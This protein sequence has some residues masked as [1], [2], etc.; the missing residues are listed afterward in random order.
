MSAG[1]QESTL[2]YGRWMAIETTTDSDNAIQTIQT[3]LILLETV[4]QNPT[5]TKKSNPLTILTQ[6][7]VNCRLHWHDDVSETVAVRTGR[8]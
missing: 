1:N 6:T 4:P 3:Q 8:P 2:N 7:I 5:Q